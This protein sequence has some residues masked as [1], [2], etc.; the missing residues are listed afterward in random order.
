[1]LQKFA[2]LCAICGVQLACAGPAAQPSARAVASPVASI[3]P[4]AQGQ[5]R[6]VRSTTLD[7]AIE[8]KLPDKEHWTIK[9]GPGWLILE[10]AQ[11]ASRVALRTWRAERLVRRA[12]C[13]AEAR[14]KRPEIP[15]VREDTVIERRLFAA[16]ADFESEL[17]VGVEA[18]PFGLSGFAIVFGSSV[19]RCYAAV[20]TTTQAGGS[21]E[22]QIATRLG[23]AVDQI[24]SRVRVRSVDERAPRRRL[25]STP[26]APSE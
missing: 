25:I 18:T 8:L 5:T 20:F 13:E 1:M 14:L 21:A 24:L 17:S 7:F 3:D 22:Q 19:G 4:W 10:H 2:F 23:L 12:E 15:L 6:R 26:R 16:P 9:D 11:S